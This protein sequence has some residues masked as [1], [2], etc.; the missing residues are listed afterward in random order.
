MNHP[1]GGWKFAQRQIQRLT[2]VDRIAEMLQANKKMV[3]LHV[4]NVF[5]APR[6]AQTNTSV[7]GAAAVEGA[8][9]EYGAEGARQLMMW[10]KASHWT[11]FVPR[12]IALLRENSFRNP[13][14]LAQEPLQFYLAA[15]SE[16]A[17]T[18]LTKRF[19]NRI[20]FQARSCASER[21]DF[22]DCEGM[23]YSIVDMLNLG[24]TKLILGSGWSSYSE[25]ASYMGGDQGMPVPILMAGRDFGAMVD[26][27]KKPSRNL[28]Q[29]ACC[30][31]L[32]DQAATTGLD[33]S[34]NMG[35]EP[36]RWAHASAR[37][38]GR[39]GV[40]LTAADTAARD[41][42]VTIQRLWPKP[43]EI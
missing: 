26:D 4:R 18:G 29:P 7:T 21:C 17:Y 19:P 24:R 43:F 34:E 23:I 5:D 37:G 40:L 12:M 25:V 28:P 10:R 15:D 36:V 30:N 11:N 31:P 38:L 2:P 35:V 32:V 6:D 9:K 33:F 39:E 41:D 3:G 14:G 22:R 1:A 20:K 8:Q 16:D 27:A 13:L 42:S